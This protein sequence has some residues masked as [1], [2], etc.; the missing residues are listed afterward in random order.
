MKECLKTEECI[1]RSELWQ[2]ARKMKRTS[3]WTQCFFTIYKNYFHKNTE[4][5]FIIVQ[6]FVN[7]PSYCKKKMLWYLFCVLF[8]GGP[9]ARGCKQL[10][11]DYDQL[12][13]CGLK[14]QESNQQQTPLQCGFGA[15]LHCT[16]QQ[17][18]ADLTHIPNVK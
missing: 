2:N 5:Y 10:E 9:G 17:P 7:L 3:C 11:L 1:V 8:C 18:S 14:H 13:S 6:W 4:Y 16:A 15:A 12:K